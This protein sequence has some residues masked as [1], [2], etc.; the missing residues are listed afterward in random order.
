M[1]R[2]ICWAL[3]LVVAVQISL[4]AQGASAAE[5]A[6]QSSDAQRDAQSRA[7]SSTR[8]TGTLA[9]GI[10]L[11]SGRTNL[12]GVQ[13]DFEGAKAFSKKTGF[14]ARFSY[15][16]ARSKPPDSN[17]QVTLEERFTGGFDFE[18]S[19]LS[20]V[21]LMARTEF[22]R[23]APGSI[24]HRFEEMVGAGPVLHNDRA[25]LRLVPGISFL[26]QN[27]RDQSVDG[28]HAFYGFYQDSRVSINKEWAFKE[29]L[30]LLQHAASGGDLFYEGHAS[31]AG[32]ITRVVGVEIRYEHTQDTVL[33]PGIIGRYQKI[34]T[35]LQVKF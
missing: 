24:E 5:A 16:Y 32:M 6:A 3:V 2:N 30:L 29:S 23:N 34:V 1:L 7:A 33:P 27:L 20:R 9:G 8:F 13:M 11:E 17:A 28:Y 19:P 21:V 31:L 26:S 15:A 4:H 35:G 18:S 14:G 22:E 10:S 12:N 25:E